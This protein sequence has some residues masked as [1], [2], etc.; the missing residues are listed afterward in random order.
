MFEY[1]KA[2]K[3]DATYRPNV[4]QVFY[5]PNAVIEDSYNY[6]YGIHLKPGYVKE[7]RFWLID[8]ERFIGKIA[9]RHELTPALL[10]FAGNI[11]YEVRW[12]KCRK[13][14]GTQML[15]MGLQFCKE[16]LGLQRVLITCNDG[17]IA[18]ARVAEKNGGILENRVINHL[19]RETVITRRYW[20]DTS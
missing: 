13:G 16:E 9:I 2:V 1:R 18:S 6:E 20:I 4:A 8:H 11:A 19:N 12:S 7:T 15:S 3:E 17:N 14:Y 5:D 10:Q